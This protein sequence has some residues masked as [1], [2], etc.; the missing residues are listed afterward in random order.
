MADEV[1][2]A[3]GPGTR[4]RT[5]RGTTTRVGYRLYRITGHNADGDDVFLWL[6][7]VGWSRT[8]DGARAMIRALAEKGEV[9][10]DD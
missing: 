9:S 10:S 8:L 1:R 2:Y 3:I 5:S 7:A 6:E 4:E